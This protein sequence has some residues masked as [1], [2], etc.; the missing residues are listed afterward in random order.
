MSESVI[1]NTKELA[2]TPFRKDALDILEEGYR[3]INTEKVI[4]SQIKVKDGHL[5][6]KGRDID[7]NSYERVFFIGIGKCAASAAVVFENILGKNLSDGITIDVRGVKL[8]KI[9]SKIG[10][11]PFPSKENIIATQSIKKMI[12]G[13]TENDLIISV[14]SGGGSALLCLPHEIQCNILIDITKALMKKGA[15][16]EELNTVRKHLSLIQGGQFAQLAYPAEVVSFIFS[17]VP[18]N[19]IGNIASGPTVLDITTKK[20]AEKIL[21]KYNILT[22]CSLPNCEV[23]ETPKEEKYFEKVDNILLLTNN[24]ALFAMKEKAE[25]LGYRAIIVDDKIEGEASTIGKFIAVQAKEKTC[26]LYGGETTVVVKNRGKGGRN[27]ELVLGALPEIKEDSIIVAAASDGWDNSDVAGAI[28]DK[29][30]LESAEKAGLSTVDFL[31]KNNSYKF[32]ETIGGHI[33]TGRL[34]SNV[35]DLY[36]T[37]SK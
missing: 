6:V 27:Q 30:L 14:I 32:F 33:K 17:D 29:A 5:V 21:V 18:G 23:V 24:N 25:I 37:L 13:A 15:D 10:T 19:N 9:K 26:L 11:H 7:L 34:G 1:K 4:T 22:T 28:G 8:Q 36:F 3:A 2:T 20:D 35:S 16:I 12:E 31:E